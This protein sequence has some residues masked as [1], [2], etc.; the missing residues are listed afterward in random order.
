L[1][2]DLVGLASGSR[3]IPRLHFRQRTK[4][5]WLGSRIDGD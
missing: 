4:A 5:L 2:N 3:Y 1:L